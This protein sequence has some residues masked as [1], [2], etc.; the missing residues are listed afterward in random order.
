LFGLLQSAGSTGDIFAS[1]FI[2]HATG[3]LY[4]DL[5]RENLPVCV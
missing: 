4:A 1:V 2:C 5:I 3:W